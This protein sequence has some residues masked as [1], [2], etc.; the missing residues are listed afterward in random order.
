MQEETRVT[1]HLIRAM[2][3]EAAK[4][5]REI[6]KKKGRYPQ[7]KPC[8]IYVIKKHGIDKISHQLAD[9]CLVAMSTILGGRGGNVTKRRREA[10]LIEIKPRKKSAKP[11]RFPELLFPGLGFPVPT[12]RSA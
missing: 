5:R 3:D 8:I 11:R 1:E 4:I 2:A 12:R 6:Y 9:E 7:T 10:G